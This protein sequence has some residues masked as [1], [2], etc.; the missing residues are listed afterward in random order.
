MTK[1]TLLYFSFSTLILSSCFTDSKEYHFEKPRS[2]EPVAFSTKES[3]ALFNEEY[4]KISLDSLKNNLMLKLE[5]KDGMKKFP[6][7]KDKKGRELSTT[8]FHFELYSNGQPVQGADLPVYAT[9]QR[10]FFMYGYTEW[11][12]KDI[13]FNSDTID[14]KIA[15]ALYYTIPYYAFNKLKQGVNEIEIKISQEVFCSDKSIRV[16]RIDTLLKDSVYDYIR[17]YAPLSFLKT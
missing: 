6:F 8:C 15:G 9:N 2:P 11:L 10:I 17:S 16:G 14:L 12:G 7:P 3:S 1:S 13:G 5:F 4:F